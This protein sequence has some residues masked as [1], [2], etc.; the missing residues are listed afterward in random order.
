MRQR[1]IWK[2]DRGEIERESAIEKDTEE[3]ERRD[4][5]RVR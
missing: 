5:E 3:R 1:K 2:K 4:R